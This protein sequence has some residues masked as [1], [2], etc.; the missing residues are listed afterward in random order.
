MSHAGPRGPDARELQSSTPFSA[1]QASAPAVALFVAVRQGNTSGPASAPLALPRPEVQVGV[2]RRDRWQA[3]GAGAG[4]ALA[5]RADAQHARGEQPPRGRGV[6]GA[7]APD[8][9]LPP[10]A[11]A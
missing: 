7:Q 4:A 2:Q 8:R 6:R 10:R 9:H 1:Q 5:A 11:L 3:R